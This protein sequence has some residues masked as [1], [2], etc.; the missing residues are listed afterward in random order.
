MLL[1]LKCCVLGVACNWALQFWL[2]T[3]TRELLST[4]LSA[5][6]MPSLSDLIGMLQPALP[7]LLH[8]TVLR[9]RIG[10]S[11][12]W[13]GL[14]HSRSFLSS[15]VMFPSRN[16]SLPSAA[17]QTAVWTQ[18]WLYTAK[19]TD[20]CCLCPGPCNWGHPDFQP[21][22]ATLTILVCGSSGSSPP[23]VS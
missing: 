22:S 6:P 3:A 11:W 14:S 13:G 1:P 15:W 7:W 2:L 19:N 10:H 16:V 17:L 20:C 4:P 9:S 12:S 21:L 18:C 8:A 5:M 23:G